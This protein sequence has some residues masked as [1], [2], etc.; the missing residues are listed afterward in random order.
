MR[1]QISARPKSVAASLLEEQQ[2]RIGPRVYTS[3]SKKFA[4]RVLVC[5][6]SMLLETIAYCGDVLCAARLSY[7]P[8]SDQRRLYNC[9]PNALVVRL[10]PWQEL[11]KHSVKKGGSAMKALRRWEACAHWWHVHHHLY[12]SRWHPQGGYRSGQ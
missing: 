4:R 3:A 7:R 2:S 5:V 6:H 8:C 1:G 11:R 9:L 12:I 10:G